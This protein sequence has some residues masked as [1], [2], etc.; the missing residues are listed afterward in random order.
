MRLLKLE[1]NGELSLNEFYGTELP[2]YAILSHTW[3][4]IDEEVVFKDFL[5]N[6]E[7]EK[8]GYQKIQFCKQRVAQDGLQYFWIDTCAIDKTSSAELTEAINSM[9]QWYRRASKCNV[10]LSDVSAHS[11][12]EGDPQ[13][14]IQA[15]EKSRWFTRGWTLQEL[16]APS[17]VEFFSVEGTLLGDKISLT[18]DISKITGISEKAI[19]GGLIFD[20]HI[21]ER[22]SWAEKRQTTREEDAAYSLLGLFDVHMPLIYGEGR[23]KA[24]ARLN[25]EIKESILSDPSR[26]NKLIEV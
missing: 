13:Q 3:G 7:K 10:Y 1:Q 22:L 8:A 25:R 12:A 2:T 16:I 4:P 5:Q 15:F 19:K 23:E 21:N 24:L 26:S 11:T 6:T 17:S 9:F 14:W 20:F 18:G